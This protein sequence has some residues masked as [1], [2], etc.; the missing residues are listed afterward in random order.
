MR[1]VTLFECFTAVFSDY[2]QNDKSQCRQRYD[3]ILS[4]TGGCR[5][6]HIVPLSTTPC[7]RQKYDMILSTTGGCR[8]GYDVIVSTTRLCR[9]VFIVKSISTALLLY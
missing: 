5:Q 4:T 7:C 8:L 2:F 3:M 9:Q 6:N 1:H